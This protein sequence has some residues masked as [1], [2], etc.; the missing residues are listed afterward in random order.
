MLGGSLARSMAGKIRLKVSISARW[1]HRSQI[2]FLPVLGFSTALLR[3]LFEEI[4]HVAVAKT[5]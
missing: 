2:S 4:V 1:S 5:V 3:V